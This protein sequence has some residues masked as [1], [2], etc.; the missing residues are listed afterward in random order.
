M[1]AAAS[2]ITDTLTIYETLPLSFSFLSRL[3]SHPYA[4]AH[5]VHEM[6][7]NDNVL[8][9][10]IYLFY[11]TYLQTDKLITSLIIKSSI[12]LQCMQINITKQ[13]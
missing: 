4:D 10:H 9:I 1:N 12:T 2:L 13:I 3:Q 6:L 8:Q 7:S 5:K 11:F